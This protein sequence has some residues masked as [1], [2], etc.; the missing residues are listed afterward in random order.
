MS[1]PLHLLRFKQEA[2]AVNVN[3]KVV[4]LRRA[5]DEA[6]KRNENAEEVCWNTTRLQFEQTSMMYGF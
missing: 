4:N 2:E 3:M 5:L 6:V 1:A